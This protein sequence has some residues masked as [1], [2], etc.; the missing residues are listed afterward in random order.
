MTRRHLV[1]VAALLAAGLLVAAPAPKAP[2]QLGPTTKEEL[3]TG[4]K[5]MA[6]VLTAVH[7]YLDANNGNW[8]TD[9][10][11][12]GGKPILSWRVRLLPYLEQETLY[13][14]F[15]LSEAW[16]GTAN[17]KLIEQMPDCFAPARKVT[18]EKGQTFYQGF[19]GPDAPFWAGKQ[20]KF[21]AS[22]PDGTS[23][24]IA[25]VEGGEPVTW[26][27]PADLPFDPTGDLPKLGG[28]YGDEFWVGMCDGSVRLAVTRHVDAEQFR[29]AVTTADGFVVDLDSALG[30]GPRMR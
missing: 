1:L 25:L 18:K 29:R 6:T 19:D 7:N 17:R 8:P 22:F 2:E 30:R 15:D 28:V 23:N 5:R 12:D 3:R 9:I 13:K 11:D 14:Q 21:P 20:P 16:D 24:T 4:R 10:T 26:T 27:K